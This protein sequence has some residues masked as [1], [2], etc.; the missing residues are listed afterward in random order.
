VTIEIQL[1]ELHHR[2]S[3][4]EIEWAIMV[5]LTN[6]RDQA[7]DFATTISC[8]GTL[9]STIVGASQNMAAMVTLLDTLPTHSVDGVDK[10]YHQLKDILGIATTQQVESSL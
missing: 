7:R 1:A 3:T 6:A 5:D 4:L 2:K 9:C 10:V 8:K